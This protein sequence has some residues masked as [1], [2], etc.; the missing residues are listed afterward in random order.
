MPKLL[1]L[2]GSMS[3]NRLLSVADPDLELNG[4]GF[5][6]LALPAFLLSV[7]SFFT[8]NKGGARPPRLGPQTPP[9]DPPLTI[10]K[11]LLPN[12]SGRMPVLEEEMTSRFY[13]FA[14]KS[15]QIYTKK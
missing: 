4:G 14:Q 9:L 1:F 5:A 10:S 15:Q 11:V 8:Q 2:K 12:H 13:C 7:I 3:P 6:L